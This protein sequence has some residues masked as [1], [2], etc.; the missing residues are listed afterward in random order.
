MK[1]K[2][3]GEIRLNL[4]INFSDIIGSNMKN[5]LILL[6]FLS[7]SLF[8]Y[9]LNDNISVRGFATFDSILSTD[10]GTR[11]KGI[12]GTPY[13]LEE[14]KF[15][16]EY[17]SM[18]LQIDGQL[19]DS[20]SFMAQGIYS[21]EGV[22]TD[23]KAKL[24]W[25]LLAYNF[26]EDYQLRA[27]IMKVPFMQATETR[28]INYTF[29]WN[30]P[31]LIGVNGFKKM[32]GVDLRKKTYIE[33]VDI[34]L[35]LT[36]GKAEHDRGVDINKY[37]WNVSSLI[38]YEDSWL[39][40]SY[41]ELEFDKYGMGGVVLEDDVILTSI[42]VETK[43]TYDNI[44]IYAGIGSNTNEAI[45]DLEYKYIS[46]SYDLDLIRPYLLYNKLTTTGLI[47]RAGGGPPSPGP[48]PVLDS[49]GF[50]IEENHSIGTRYDFHENAALKFQYTYRKNELKNTSV[51]SSS[52]NIYTITLDM[53]F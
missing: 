48:P 5:I 20:F 11:V 31:Q 16:H 34:E 9:D 36:Y 42:S 21:K 46:L 8:S 24:E 43:L 39:R 13:T 38:S 22:N 53:V 44:S 29:L 50:S 14:N 40:L 12:D 27:G 45:P 18:G 17:S 23:Y 7:A 28:N 3:K 19:N 26:G 47:V 15:S 51:T 1:Q 6:T 33:D 41:G 32:E 25:L 35:Q 37:L 49:S 10:E 2:I 4:E 30:R 52:A